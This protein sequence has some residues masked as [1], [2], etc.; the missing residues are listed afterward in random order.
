METS[1]ASSIKG[2]LFVISELNNLPKATKCHNQFMHAAAFHFLSSCCSKF[3]IHRVGVCI[4]WLIWPKIAS[5]AMCAHEGRPTSQVQK[6]QENQEVEWAE[7]RLNTLNEIINTSR[8]LIQRWSRQIYAK[9]MHRPIEVFRIC[10]DIDCQYFMRFC[11]NAFCSMCF[12][13]F[14]LSLFSFDFLLLFCIEATRFVMQ[15]IL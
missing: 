7:A 11:F 4:L 15:F 14:S 10:C 5:A 9:H 2:C 8:I 13:L 1:S 6:D 12:S 3:T